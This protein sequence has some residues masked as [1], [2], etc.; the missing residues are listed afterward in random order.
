MGRQFPDPHNSFINLLYF[1]QGFSKTCSPEAPTAS[2]LAYFFHSF[3][4]C[5]CIRQSRHQNCLLPFHNLIFSGN[6]DTLSY[7][8]PTNRGVPAELSSYL[9]TKSKLPGIF[10]EV[11]CAKKK[12]WKRRSP[13]VGCAN[14]FHYKKD[15][16]YIASPTTMS[17][18]PAAPLNSEAKNECNELVE[19][20][21]W[22][23]FGAVKWIAVFCTDCHINMKIN[24][25]ASLCMPV[26]LNLC[27]CVSHTC[28]GFT[29][30]QPSLPNN[31]ANITSH[32]VFQLCLFPFPPF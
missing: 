13:E 28:S 8:S 6:P 29:A 18:M 27:S 19:W 15:I 7:F 12:K 4:Q 22:R 3:P 30:T 26:C 16:I 5:F 21:S 24:V 14:A 9:T 2:W 10:I 25:G 23:E 20:I 32:I 17:T 11:K 31:L 1:R